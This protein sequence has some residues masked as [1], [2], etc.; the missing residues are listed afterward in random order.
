V[1]E[2]LLSWF[3][4]GH[5]GAFFQSC[6]NEA[7]D[8]ECVECGKNP[9][10]GVEIK[11][12]KFITSDPSISSSTR[13]ELPKKREVKTSRKRKGLHSITKL[14]IGWFVCIIAILMGLRY[15][16][17]K[18]EIKPASAS[19][20]SSQIL[21]SEENLILLQQFLPRC[22][23]NFSQF[24]TAGTI[25]ERGQFTL[26]SE[27]AIARMTQFD[28]LNPLP[29]MDPQMI[30]HLRSTALKLPTGRAIESHWK[31][32]E[33]HVLSTVFVEDA[34]DW[35]LDWEHF[36]HFSEYN[37][38]LFLAGGG[39]SEVEFRLLAR[40]RLAEERKDSST[41]SFTLYSTSFG[42]THDTGTPSPEFTVSRDSRN[43]R[44][45]DAAF[46]LARAGKSPFRSILPSIDP[47]GYIRVRVRIRRMDENNE[48]RFELL[49]LIAC[50]WYSTVES[51]I[52]IPDQPLEK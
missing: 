19:E 13:N 43:G 41:L 18:E 14:M 21:D 24:L 52:E 8:H 39:R 16:W 44:L 12:D 1:K 3:H 30:T 6:F 23:E 37:W 25:A 46:K 45:L 26:S 29:Q 47:D 40:E 38:P 9:S 7:S 17:P 27:L 33:G 4:C 35:R 34:N 49:D 42:N 36:V 51:G 15:L 2:N 28:I 48:R 20:T 5:C 31:S 10:L 32:S 22:K 50:H 11:T